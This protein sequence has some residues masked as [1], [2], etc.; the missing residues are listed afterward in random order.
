MKKL[1]A[2][3]LAFALLFAL[4]ACAQPEPPQETPPQP[5]PDE[6]AI[7]IGAVVQEISGEKSEPA[8]FRFDSFSFGK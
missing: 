1:L 5:E 7:E 6:F 4:A 8:D 2:L 3:L